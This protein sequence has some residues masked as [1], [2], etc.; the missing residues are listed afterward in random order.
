[1]VKVDDVLRYESDAQTIIERFLSIYDLSDEKY[2]AHSY[3]KV[4]FFSSE[5]KPR[6]YDS[7]GY[8]GT[9]YIKNRTENNEENDEST[10]TELLFEDES[11]SKVVSAF[12]FQEV[13]SD[14]LRKYFKQLFPNVDTSKSK[15]TRKVTI[16]YNGRMYH[17]IND[18]V[19]EV[20]EQTKIKDIV[21]ANDYRSF[22]HSV[23]GSN[24]HRFPSKF[25]FELLVNK[26]KVL[27]EEEIIRYEM[28]DCLFDLL[29]I[30]KS[31]NRIE[32][33]RNGQ[34]S[35]EIISRNCKEFIH[36]LL[37]GMTG[38]KKMTSALA[39]KIDSIRKNIHE[40]YS[41]S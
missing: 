28:S 9:S 41:S 3:F 33:R 20:S 29:V 5:R 16:E 27:D 24:V 13:F 22:N 30:K 17:V 19:F 37:N 25:T 15:I 14:A 10:L 4:S 32:Y 18:E 36:V 31:S 39:Q 35:F 6:L 26:G 12:S 11:H 2:L 21:Y 34:Y 38:I 1:M 7:T 8:L 23:F 40:K